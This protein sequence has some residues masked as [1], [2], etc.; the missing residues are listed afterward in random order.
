MIR[1]DDQRIPQRALYW[2]VR[3]SREDHIDR[4]QTEEERSTKTCNLEEAEVKLS[5]DSNGIR[6]GPVHP[7]GYGLNQCQGQKLFPL[8][9]NPSASKRMEPHQ[10]TD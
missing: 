6:G 5:T 3:D 4:E 9:D 10:S 8:L 2:E 7:L 1:T